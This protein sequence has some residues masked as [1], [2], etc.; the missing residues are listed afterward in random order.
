M[1]LFEA[2]V[3]ERKHE[4]P[5]EYLL[6]LCSDQDLLAILKNQSEDLWK[7]EVAKDFS[8]SHISVLIAS[9]YE[10]MRW[11]VQQSKEAIPELCVFNQEW[12]DAFFERIQQEM[13][14]LAHKPCHEWDEY[15]LANYKAIMKKTNVAQSCYALYTNDISH[16]D[17][18]AVT[19]MPTLFFDT[20]E[21]AQV[22]IKDKDEE[23]VIYELWYFI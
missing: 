3:S 12:V 6:E 2:M 14:Y 16:H 15:D 21:E 18:L 9:D 17:A 19:T 1:K 10:I 7:Q 13:H 20:R 8:R 4:P 23:F 22:T 11:Q 5:S